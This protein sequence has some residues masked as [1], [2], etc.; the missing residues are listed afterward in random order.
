VIKILLYLFF[1][2]STSAIAEDPACKFF[3]YCGGNGS[4]NTHST[5]SVATSASLNPAN[6]SKVKGFGLET[7]YQPH[8]SLGFTV[9]SGNGKLGALLSPSLE[10]SFF[11]NRSI[12]IDDVQKA[13]LLDKIQYKNRKTSFAFGAALIDKNNV[14]LNLGLSA[15]RNPDVKIINSGVGLSLRLFSLN[16]GTYYYQDDVKIALGS[17]IN[18]YT[19]I[20]YSTQYLNTNYQERFTVATYTAGMRVKNLTLDYG[21]IK[22]RYKFYN[23]GTSI[24]IYSGAL[25]S[26]KFLFN[27]ASRKEASSNLQYAKGSMIIKRDKYDYYYGAQYLFNQHLI[28]G[29][30]Y[31]NFLLKELSGTLTIFF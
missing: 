29:L 4:S 17:Y 15:K 10:N 11:G 2:T 25:S 26:G 16:F 13:R 14:E 18:P 5:P 19:N 3:K 6:I 28:V 23:E 7:V 31:N 12:E 1:F 8:N 20:L 22:T 9:V 21:V 24:Y 30:Q 27:F